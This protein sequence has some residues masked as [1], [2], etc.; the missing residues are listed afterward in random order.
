MKVYMPLACPMGGGHPN[1]GNAIDPAPAQLLAT[2][3]ERPQPLRAKVGV[4][5]RQVPEILL[6]ET[7]VLALPSA[8]FGPDNFLAYTDFSSCL[9]RRFVE[10]GGRCRNTFTGSTPFRKP[11][12]LS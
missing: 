4:L 8:E 3:A 10:Q 12:I 1:K 7:P 5:F 9:R 6:C 2:A 11:Y